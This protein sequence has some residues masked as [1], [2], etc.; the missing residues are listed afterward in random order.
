MSRTPKAPKPLWEP[1]EPV[2]P[3]PGCNAHVDRPKCFFELGASCPRHPVR[4]AWLRV[5]RPLPR[6]KGKVRK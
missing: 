4:D 3:E 6:A 5:R 2:C 1:S